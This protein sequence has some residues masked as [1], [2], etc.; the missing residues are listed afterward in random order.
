[1]TLN[2]A[3]VLIPSAT[4]QRMGPGLPETLKTK[5]ESLSNL[6]SFDLQ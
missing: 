5:C 1:M 6:D 2:K 4:I 3:P